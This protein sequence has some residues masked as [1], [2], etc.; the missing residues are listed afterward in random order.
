[1]ETIKIDSI[2]SEFQKVIV[3]AYGDRPLVRYALK[4][5]DG[6]V[7][8]KSEKSFQEFQGDI[9]DMDWI[10]WP[11][12]DVYLYQE[13]RYNKLNDLYKTQNINDLNE[14]WKKQ[15]KAIL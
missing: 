11:E 4:R 5:N 8:V 7:M 13:E 1:M 2:R 9:D 3:K 12:N 14:V 10:G 15:D 6:I